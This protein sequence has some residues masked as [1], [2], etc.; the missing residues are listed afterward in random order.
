MTE[1]WKQHLQRRALKVP[2]GHHKDSENL[3]KIV[4]LKDCLMSMDV[5]VEKA[6][7]CTSPPTY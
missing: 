7:F 4:F 2:D 6:V 1:L 3:Q 5:L